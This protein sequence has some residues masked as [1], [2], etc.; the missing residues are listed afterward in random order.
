MRSHRPSQTAIL[1]ARSTYL[2]SR[3]PQ[4]SR[5]V[6]LGAGEACRRFLEA[7][8]MSPVQLRLADRAWFRSLALFSERF[9]IP[10]VSLHYAARKRWLEEA[11]RR[12]LADGIAQ[13]VV[14]GAGLD[15]LA[16]RLHR[17]LPDV[18]F[19]ET[20]HPA[21]QEVKRRALARWGELDANLQLAPLDLAQARPEEVLAA[22]PEYRPEADTLF[23]AEGLTMYLQPQEMDA[24]CA[25]VRQHAGPGSR[26]AFTFMEPQADGK[27]NFPS[28]TPLVRPWL[29]LVGEPF[30]WGVRR[31]DLPRYVEERGFAL[32]ELAGA[33]ELRQRYLVP[34]GLAD[35]RLAVGEYLA[36]ARRASM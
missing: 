11:A 28:A 2:L 34:A 6:P 30:T 25:F 32:A 18:L 3:D 22:L 31:Q 15:T 29:A 24:L 23:I 7:A 10:G 21:T 17:E 14:L 35:R 1:I 27:V 13:V 20:D 26:F 4:L 19:V 12:A 8:G 36:L 5:L 9:A 33:E 16:L